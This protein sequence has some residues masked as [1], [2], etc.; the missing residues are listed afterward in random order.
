MN[1]GG[2][3]S[4]FCAVASSGPVEQQNLI[5]MRIGIII[6]LENETIIVG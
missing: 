5:V 4:F 3:F 2:G 6:V 1:A